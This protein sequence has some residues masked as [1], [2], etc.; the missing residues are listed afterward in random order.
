MK[1][2]RYRILSKLGAGGMRVVL[3]YADEVNG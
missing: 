2:S 3:F 1:I